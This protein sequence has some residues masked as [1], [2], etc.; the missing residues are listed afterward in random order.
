MNKKDFVNANRSFVDRGVNMNLKNLWGK[1]PNE[2]VVKEGER[3]VWREY[4][5]QC[6]TENKSS[7]EYY[8]QCL[9]ENKS[10]YF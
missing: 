4:Y 9:A 3:W 2:S 8:P 1:S 6:L 10:S 5:P 7:F